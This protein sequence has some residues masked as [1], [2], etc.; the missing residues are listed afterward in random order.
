MARRPES[1]ESAIDSYIRRMQELGG[2]SSVYYISFR[3][4]SMAVF[5]IAR[6]FQPDAIP[7]NVTVDTVRKTLDYMRKNLASSS[8]KIYTSY[9]KQL[10]RASGNY[11]FD[12]LRIIYPADTRPNVDWLTLD[13]ALTLM[14]ADLEPVDAMIINLALGHGLRRSEIINLRLSDV[15]QERRFITVLGKGRGGGKVRSVH[16]HPKFHPIFLDWME[17]RTFLAQKCRDDVSDNAV[18]VYERGGLLKRYSISGLDD[19]LKKLTASLGIEFSCHTLRRTFG[20]EMFHSGVSVVTIAK[21]LG[22]SSTEM[23]LKYIGIDLDDM[24][25]A[26]SQFILR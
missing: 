22:H 26:M 12:K 16:F 24:A 23:T 18:L 4:G 2:Y 11:E 21:I 1:V 7:K 10:M 25:D 5:K 13:D 6:M 8:M 17:H 9:L 19:R 3:H 15:N 20:R 14:R